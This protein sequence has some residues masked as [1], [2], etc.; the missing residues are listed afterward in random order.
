RSQSALDSLFLAIH[1]KGLQICV[2][3]NGDREIDMVLNAFEKVY[4]DGNPLQLHH[5]IEH[6]SVVNDS[7]IK[8]IKRLGVIPVLHCYINELGD[9]LEP[10]GDDRLNNMFATKSFLNAGVLPALHSDAP[11]SGYNTLERWES[12]VVRIAP[13]GKALG[14][15]QCIDAEDAL[16]MYT[17]GS[18]AA[19]D[20]P[21]IKGTIE[22]GKLADFI[23]LDKD[24]TTIPPKQIHTLQIINTWVGGKLVYDASKK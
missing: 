8:R 14:A 7:I 16:M 15:N 2:H 6:C 11:V 23:L 3:S 22:T 10:Y 17:K 21:A 12:A 13:S 9:L 24:P 4:A 19:T 20:E 5:R 18:A 1:R